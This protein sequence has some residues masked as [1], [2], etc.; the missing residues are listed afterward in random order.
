MLDKLNADFE[1]IL[2]L[3]KKCPS[4]LQEVALKALLDNWFRL[5]TVTPVSALATAAATPA[6]STTATTAPSPSQLPGSFTPFT[7]ANGLTAAHLQKVYHPVGPAAQLVISDVPGKGKAG[8][9]ISLALLLSVRQAMG[10]GTFGCGIEE[11]RQMCLHYNCY[12]TANF[13]ATLN[14]NADLFKSR[15][16]GEDIELSASGMK[17]AADVI[18]GA[19][20]ES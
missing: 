17:R 2:R 3:V 7:V 8:K 9:Q 5:N 12:D 18:K 6:A 11:L 14:N 13:A 16:K 1:E 19:A 15:K 10:G 20:S 4:E